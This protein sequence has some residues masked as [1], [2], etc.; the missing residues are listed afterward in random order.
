MRV[1]RY[2]RIGLHLFT[3]M[4]VLV[5]CRSDT[6]SKRVTIWHQSKAPYGTYVAYYGLH[7]LFP[8]ADL[9]I[10]HESP[11]RLLM[12]EEKK[13][14]IIITPQMDPEGSEVNAILNFVG[15]GNYVF[16]SSFYFSDSLLHA[17]NITPAYSHIYSNPGDSLRLSVYNPVDFDSLS[18]AYPG[19]AMDDWARKIDS[20]YTSILGRDARGRPDFVRFNYKGGGS[21]YLHFAPLAFSNFFLLHKNNKAYYDNVFSYIPSTVKEVIWDDYFRYDRSKSGHFSAFQ[22]IFTSAALRWAFGLLLLLFG[23]FYIFESKRK[24]RMVPVLAGLR[25]NSLDFVRTIGRL[26]Y[27]RRDN[28]D[29]AVKMVSHFQDH[30]RTRYNLHV[31]TADPAFVDR[32]SFRTGVPGAMLQELVDNIKVLQERSDLTDEELMEFHH[33]L[34][35]FYRRG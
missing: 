7:D 26:Y 6:P 22:Y 15:S 23:L 18:F 29:L 4:M 20:Q 8:N 11:A 21:L 16:I 10:N 1:G 13:A 28:H 33:Q 19:Y 32:L 5:S 30:I 3:I 14:Y 17:L 27:Q 24:Q 31:S 25:N 34:E 12:G 9:T 35:A 2:I